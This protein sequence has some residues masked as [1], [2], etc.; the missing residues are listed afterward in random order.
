M[1]EQ[2]LQLVAAIVVLAAF[3]LSQQGRLSPDSVAYLLMNAVGTALLAVLAGI[4]GDL[5]FLL[6]EGVWALYS[7][8]RLKA[9]LGLRAAAS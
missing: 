6:L 7:T 8:W 5:G 1:T 9:V 4:G 3:V 2:A